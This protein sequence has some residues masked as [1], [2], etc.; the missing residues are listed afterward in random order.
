MI[1]NLCSSLIEAKGPTYT[2]FE[3]LP[4]R[5]SQVSKNGCVLKKY[6]IILSFFENYRLWYRMPWRRTS[7]LLKHNKVGALNE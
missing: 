4:T 5:V 7:V 2:D 1:L 6:Q 3:K